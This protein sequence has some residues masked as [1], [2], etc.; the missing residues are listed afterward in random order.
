[1]VTLM[2]KSLSITIMMSCKVNCQRH[3]ALKPKNRR[4]RYINGQKRCQG[5]EI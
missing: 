4:G 5:C 3:K 2:S 1:M